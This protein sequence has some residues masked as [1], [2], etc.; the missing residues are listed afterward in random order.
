LWLR[1]AP[2]AEQQRTPDFVGYNIY[3][4]K[5]GETVPSAPINDEICLDSAFMDRSVAAGEYVYTVRSV[6]RVNNRRIESADSPGT[7]SSF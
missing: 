4:R 7:V 5:E 3:R 1:W 2:L 6:W